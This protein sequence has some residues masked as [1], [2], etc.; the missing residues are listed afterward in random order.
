MLQNQQTH[1][2]LFPLF[3]NI[4][5]KCL[6]SYK[7]TCQPYPLLKKFKQETNNIDFRASLQPLLINNLIFGIIFVSLLQVS[8]HGLPGPH[9]AAEKLPV[10]FTG[11]ILP[12]IPLFALEPLKAWTLFRRNSDAQIRK[13]YH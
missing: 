11:Q 5:T 9:A 13:A 7:L 12:P 10:L 4:Y 6:N 8:E 3:Q 2:Y 1:A